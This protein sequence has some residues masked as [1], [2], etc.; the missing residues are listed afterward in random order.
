MG[1]HFW[2]ELFDTLR[3]FG[4]LF[5]AGY[6]SIKYDRITSGKHVD[7]VE[8]ACKSAAC[9]VGRTVAA[10]VKHIKSRKSRK[11]RKGKRRPANYAKRDEWIADL[12]ETKVPAAHKVNPSHG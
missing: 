7:A 2:T 12:P 11:A 8:N 6:L 10:P 9:F 4:I 5:F 3:E 1:D